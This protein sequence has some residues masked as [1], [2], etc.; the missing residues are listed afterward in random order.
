MNETATST[1]TAEE[2]KQYKAIALQFSRD[3]YDMHCG[4][5]ETG[6]SYLESVIENSQLQVDIVQHWARSA[7]S[8]QYLEHLQAQQD[9]M[10]KRLQKEQ[11]KLTA[12]KNIKKNSLR[13]AVKR[14]LDKLP[15]TADEKQYNWTAVVASYKFFDKV[16][17][18]KAQ[19]IDTLPQAYIMPNSKVLSELQTILNNKLEPDITVEKPT[20]ALNSTN[21]S[22]KLS[23]KENQIMDTSKLL[24]YIPQRAHKLLCKLA[25]EFLDNCPEKLPQN[26]EDLPIKYL[27]VVTNV[28]QYAAVCGIDVVPKDNTPEEKERTKDNYKKFK[29]KLYETMI[30][31]SYFNITDISENQFDKMY[32]FSKIN[33]THLDKGKAY[34][35]VELGGTYAKHLI[36]SPKTYYPKA[37]FALPDNYTTAYGIALAICNCANMDSNLL[38]DRADIISVHALLK[39]AH[40]I[41]YED[42]KKQ[43]G[44]WNGK[45]KIP[46]ENALDILVEYDILECWEYRDK[47]VFKGYTDWEKAIIHFE[48]KHK[49]DHSERLAKKV[50]R[51]KQA[52]ERRE[53]ASEIAKLKIAEKK[54][55]KQQNKTKKRGKDKKNEED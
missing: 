9:Q 54:T 17:N 34:I 50:E 52:E 25:Q 32:P 14:A 26:V 16:E 36:K 46:L 13:K 3:L 39:N 2:I 12:L 23:A 49:I 33:F 19:Q 10:M 42:V 20:L 43:K 48:L 5:V 47:C 22:Y 55:E 18:G 29:K 27:T 24:N 45:I 35:T 15:P 1:P 6:I 40:L 53:I 30:M 31:L 21:Y 28:R 41:S 37:L 44:S 8:D 11:D 38:N 4:S 51:R 7:D